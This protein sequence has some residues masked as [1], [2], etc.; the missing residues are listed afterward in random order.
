MIGVVRG[1]VLYALL[2]N[3]APTGLLF[4]FGLIMYFF[5]SFSWLRERKN[6]QTNKKS[7][8]MSK[9]Y[10]YDAT[11]LVVCYNLKFAETY[12]P[13]HFIKQIKVLLFCCC[14]YL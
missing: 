1:A 8:K 14:E 3:K 12:L 9:F 10:N 11:W 4:I 13:L 2:C 6:K 7:Y 5:E